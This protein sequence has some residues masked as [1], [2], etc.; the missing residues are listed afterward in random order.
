VNGTIHDCTTQLSLVIRSLVIDEQEPQRIK[1]LLFTNDVQI[2]RGAKSLY[3]SNCLIPVIPPLANVDTLQ[4]CGCTI[5]CS[6]FFSQVKALKITNSIPGEIDFSDLGVHS[7]DE[8]SVSTI[9]GP[10]EIHHYQ[11]LQ[12]VK[13][14]CIPESDSIINV[15]CF[16]NARKLSLVRCKN[17]TDV[18]CLGNVVELDL[19][20]C[21][22]ITNFSNLSN[23]HSLNLSG[24]INISEVSCLGSVT[25]LNLSGCVNVRDVSAL[26]KVRN[27]YLRGCY[28]ISDIS[29]LGF[30]YILDLGLCPLITNVSS[31]G[32][33]YNLTLSE[34]QGND[35]SALKNVKVLD[36]S[37]SPHLVD[38]SSLDNSVEVLN[39]S[40]CDLIVNI[41]MLHKVKSLDITEC[42]QI[43][44]F[45][46]LNSLHDL[47]M[48]PWMAQSLET[49]EIEKGYETFR[50]L[51]ALSMGRTKDIDSVLTEL[52]SC[53]SLRISR[54]IL[55]SVLYLWSGIFDTS[56]SP[57]VYWWKV[58]R[59]I[60][61]VY[62][63]YE[64]TV[65]LVS[66]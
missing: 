19:S 5:Q 24:C 63:T 60:C 25:N 30:N 50:Q 15:E 17:I 27:L 33:V 59:T 1:S 10:V 32:S 44:D 35:I 16:Q 8:F 28:G 41:T 56:N 42:F 51:K 65:V 47:E 52:Q 20:G 21:I 58:S 49:I 12:G 14:I 34:F 53:R 39:I 22:G 45:T 46:G 38:L 26:G 57:S 11:A 13:T 62:N 23:C 43:K 64:S 31:L 54:S 3:I 48:N 40:Y 4:L 37:Y 9:G 2:F 18:S 55:Q 7:L 66:N 61:Y 6:S 29:Q 36:L